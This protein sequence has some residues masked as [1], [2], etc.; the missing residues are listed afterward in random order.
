MSHRIAGTLL[1]LPLILLRRART[2]DWQ[3]DAAKLVT[4]KCSYQAGV[5]Q[6]RKIHG[7]I[8]YETDRQREVRCV[9]T[10]PASTRKFDRDEALAPPIFDSAVSAAHFVTQFH[11]GRR[12]QRPGERHADDPC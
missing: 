8:A 11:Q 5:E 6:V 4:F 3:I 10:S 12:W 2:R 1:V 7:A 9:S